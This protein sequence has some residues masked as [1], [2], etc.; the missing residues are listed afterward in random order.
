MKCSGYRS[1]LG[2]KTQMQRSV[3][4]IEIDPLTMCESSE[5]WVWNGWRL[6]LKSVK[7]IVYQ[8]DALFRRDALR[9]ERSTLDPRYL[10]ACRHETRKHAAASK[11]NDEA[12]DPRRSDLRRVPIQGVR[13]P[14][15][16]VSKRLTKCPVSLADQP[17]GLLRSRQ[18]RHITVHFPDG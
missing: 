12:D 16:D 1:Y 5:Q 2:E 8:I 7:S 3:A 6:P 17:T 13:R 15:R 14:S 18:Y 4:K 9:R 10:D 11:S